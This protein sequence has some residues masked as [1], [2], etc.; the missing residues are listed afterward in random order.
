MKKILE[1][2]FIIGFVFIGAQVQAASTTGT[3]SPTTTTK[4]TPN[5]TPASSATDIKVCCASFGYGS[6]MVKTNNSYK[7][8]NKNEC[9]Y[10]AGLVGGGKEIVSD[11]FCKTTPTTPTQPVVMGCSVGF[12]FNP[13]TGKQC[14]DVLIKDGCFKGFNYSSQ[15]GQKCAIVPSV[16][17]I[18]PNGGES[19]SKG[20]IETIKW[21]GTTPVLYNNNGNSLV[22]YDISLIKEQNPCTQKTCPV[23]DSYLVANKIKIPQGGK[24][25]SFDWIVGNTDQK[26]KIVPDGAYMIQICRTDTKSCD[27]SDNYFKINSLV[28]IFTANTMEDI[29]SN[30]SLYDGRTVDVIGY[31][32]P[33]DVK[34]ESETEYLIFRSSPAMNADSILSMKFSPS[35]MK[36]PLIDRYNINNNEWI[37]IYASGI[38]KAITLSGMPNKS[39][40][41]NI[42]GLKILENIEKKPISS[43]AY[44][45]CPPA[46]VPESCPNTTIVASKDANGCVTLYKCAPSPDSGSMDP[47]SQIGKSCPSNMIN[48]YSLCI[49]GNIQADKKDGNGCTLSYKCTNPSS[50]ISST[51]STISPRIL[52]VGVKGDD[53]KAL[54]TLLGITADGSFGSMTKAKVMEWQLTNGLT[55]DGAFGNMS[56]LKAGL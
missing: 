55:P 2:L 20:K 31:V 3:I 19:L 43:N 24:T 1:G 4:V 48:P 6:N 36:K 23:A 30:V 42:S 9:V 13:E 8:V 14:S 33:G 34:S 10:P 50:T 40:Q 32:Y 49:D 18:S 37:K 52:K 5:T 41:L 29:L 51:T 12:N 28:E 25:N 53:V 38:I 27:L 35:S 17:I 54:Q 11:S 22:Y 16:T 39:A 45:S 44:N 21:S 7:S 56:R 47:N 15:T 46:G 26:N